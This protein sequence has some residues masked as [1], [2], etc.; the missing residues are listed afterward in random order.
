MKELEFI[1]IIKNTLTDSSLIGD[2][3]AFLKDEN[4]AITQDTLVED[5]HF[6]LKTT[7]PYELGYKSVAVNLS[8]LA[9]AAANPR[10]VLI[11][12]SF[13]PSTDA[14]W[15]RAFYK[16]AGFICDQHNVIVA[17]GDI[18]GGNKLSITVTAIGKAAKSIRR[19]FA[20]IGDI[21]FVTG[22]HGNSRAGLEI[23]EKKLTPQENFTQAHKMPTPK[24]KEGL[25]IAEICQNPAI[26]DTSDGLA[27]ALYKIAEAS[28]VTIEVDFDKIPYDKNL[29]E[30]FPKNWQNQILFG[31]EDYELL[32]C[33]RPEDFDKLKNQ[34]KV[35]PIGHVIGK[36][37]APS[38]IKLNEKTLKIDKQTIENMAF[39][40]F[41]GVKE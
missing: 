3:T 2:D 4:L 26:M 40:H 17:G 37:N 5:V 6:R 32:A 8:D 13:P 29:K 33:V 19:S 22:E 15:V 14:D 38:I 31:G 30:I 12:L 18:T 11:S 28:K 1:E 41:E 7:T 9:A 39:D 16:G 25:K 34:L 10:Y 36:T 35:Y 24:I 23:L 21:V 27:D 20:E